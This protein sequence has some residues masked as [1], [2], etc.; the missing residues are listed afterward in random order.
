M[1]TQNRHDHIVCKAMDA[2]NRFANDERAENELRELMVKL[3]MP[4]PEAHQLAALGRYV[5][6]H[7]YRHNDSIREVGL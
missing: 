6:F 7:Q 4:E 5:S 3:G 2:S 1:E